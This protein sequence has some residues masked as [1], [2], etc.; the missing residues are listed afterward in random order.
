MDSALGRH[1][2]P[3]LTLRFPEAN[4]RIILGANHLDLLDH[5]EVYA[6]LRTWL[7]S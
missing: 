1:A 2:L 4:Q 3:E 7:A 5:P 6:A